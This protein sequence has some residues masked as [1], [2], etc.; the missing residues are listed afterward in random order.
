MFKE[1]SLPTTPKLVSSGENSAV[2]EIPSLY[3]GYGITIGNALRR[4][5][6]SS[7]GGCAIT[8]AHFDTGL[9]E[10]STLPG[11]LEDTLDIILNLKQVRLDFPGEDSVDLTIEKT[12]KG[13]IRAKDIKGPGGLIIANPEQL[14]ATIT[15]DKAKLKINL[16]AER[17]VGYIPAEMREKDRVEPGSIVLDAMF[18]PVKNIS[19]EVEDMRVQDRTDFNLLRLSIETDGTMKPEEALKQATEILIKHFQI[20][21]ESVARV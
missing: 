21:D 10:F 8:K 4:V 3:P 1:V 16:I 11:I 15:E 14:I 12:G 18:S 7:V 19:F 9:H 20:I 13:E 5:L 6:L 2:F 17:G